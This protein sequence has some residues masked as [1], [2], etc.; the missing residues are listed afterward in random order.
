MKPLEDMEQLRPGDARAGVL[1]GQPSVTFS[2]VERDPDLTLEGEFESVGEEIEH[3][4][5]VHLAV[6]VHRLGQR[7]AVHR[8]RQSR[9][10][11]QRAKCA[12][13][14]DG[15]F[16]QVGG[17][18][19]GLR[20]P[21][22]DP[23]EVEQRVDELEQT[24]RTAPDQVQLVAGEGRVGRR[25][26]VLHR[27]ENEG[28]GGAELVRHVGEEG[29]LRTV[30]LGQFGDPLVLSRKGADAGNTGGN[31]PRQELEE[32]SILVAEPKSRTEARHENHSGGFVGAHH[33]GEHEGAG[34]GLWPGSADQRTESGFEILD[35]D[36]SARACD[37]PDRPRRVVLE[38]QFAGGGGDA[39]FQAHAGDQGGDAAADFIEERKG[40]V[41]GGMPE[42]LLDRV[43]HRGD[44]SIERGPD[45]P[46]APE[47]EPPLGDDP[48]GGLQAR[49]EDARHRTAL[50]ADRI[51]G[52]VEVALLEK[53]VP[54][55]AQQ[56]G[57]DV[58]GAPGEDLVDHRLDDV[59]DFRPAFAPP[60]SHRAWMLGGAEDGPV[61]VV[62]ELDE[63]RSPPHEHR[64]LGRK[65]NAEHGAQGLR[66][67]LDRA[68]RRVRPV[69]G[70]HERL[71][72]AAPVEDLH[73]DPRCFERAPV[74]QSIAQRNDPSRE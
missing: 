62:V 67:R 40:Q 64:V 36:L 24:L 28:Q 5:L 27:S 33:Q 22:F 23:A 39:P 50:V 45:G 66:P 60:L 7:R 71:H 55:E 65:E 47:H 38:L 15:E 72:L 34:H 8:E 54:I 68:Y 43:K 19:S 42:H 52:V 58:R 59:P 10:F 70:A 63:V 49:D 4:L 32:V 29:R 6:H 48:V 31:L 73:G 69:D 2:C 51:V 3:D 11:D 9:S 61:T 20:A 12:G 44:V 17:L 30:E 57:F 1:D 53:A 14:V 56:S 13:Q 46:F 35:E 25:Q 37:G 26:R 21:G 16:A 41:G 18:G 74:G